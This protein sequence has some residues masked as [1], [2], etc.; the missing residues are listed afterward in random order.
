MEGK[1]TTL[2][3]NEIRCP[4]CRKKQIG[5]LPYYE[6]L[7][8]EKINGVNHYDSSSNASNSG[9]FYSFTAPTEKNF[10]KLPLTAKFFFILQ[11]I[12]RLKTKGEK[13]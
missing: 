9:C 1:S 4:Y 12:P 13:K 7:I 10:K 3:V 8:M 6:E 5:V 2:K 11:L